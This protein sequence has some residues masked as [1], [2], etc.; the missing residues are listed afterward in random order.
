MKMLLEKVCVAFTGGKDYG[1]RHVSGAGIAFIYRY[2]NN[3]GFG[4]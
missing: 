2:H 1:L 4:H 3:T